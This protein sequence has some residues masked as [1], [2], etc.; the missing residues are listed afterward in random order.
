[1]WSAG[2]ALPSKQNISACTE[3][4]DSTSSTFK[5]FQMKLAPW[6]KKNLCRCSVLL[7]V[8]LRD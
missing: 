6:G 5:L 8:S 1:M 2:F 7:P 4:A 3:S